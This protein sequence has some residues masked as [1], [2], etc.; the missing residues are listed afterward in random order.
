MDVV[1]ER[2]SADSLGE[3]L[4]LRKL[5]LRPSVL[6]HK[7]LEVVHQDH[8]RALVDRCLDPSNKARYVSVKIKLNFILQELHLFT[9]LIRI[10]Q[11]FP[12]FEFV[13][14]NV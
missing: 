6:V 3:R 2:Q 1:H 12:R 13:N 11:V 5:I 10:F 8:L 4:D 14:R 9:K 7:D